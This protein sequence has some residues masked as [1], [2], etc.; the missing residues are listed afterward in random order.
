[1]TRTAAA[2]RS[3]PRVRRF[4]RR[5]SED[6]VLLSR[7]RGRY[8]HGDPFDYASADDV[9]ELINALPKD[10]GGRAGLR[11]N[12]QWDRNIRRFWDWHVVR[13]KRE[14]S[15]A[16]AVSRS[17][18]VVAMW[19]QFRGLDKRQLEEKRGPSLDNWWH[20]LE[21]AGV[22]HRAGVRDD[23]NMWWR[24][25]I[26]LLNWQQG[27]R[28]HSYTDLATGERESA[29]SASPQTVLAAPPAQLSF[30]SASGPQEAA[31]GS[32]AAPARDPLD[33]PPPSLFGQTFFRP[34]R[35]D[36]A[37]SSNQGCRPPSVT[38]DPLVRDDLGAA[39]P[40]CL[41]RSSAPGTSPAPAPANDDAPLAVATLGGWRTAAPS[42]GTAATPADRAEAHVE[43]LQA[44]V[45]A[46]GPPLPAIR[47]AFEVLSGGE[48]PV[49]TRRR[50]AQVGRLLD[51]GD[52][53]GGPG[54]EPGQQGATAWWLLAA[55]AAHYC[56][57]EPR[58]IPRARRFGGTKPPAGLAGW[59]IVLKREIRSRLVGRGARRPPQW[60]AGRPGDPRI[61]GAGA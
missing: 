31:D 10:Q 19:P 33:E 2:P 20:R 50:V 38:A 28:W 18:L 40:P 23:H 48:S 25:E 60:Q 35:D 43:Q 11:P 9:V 61:D 21:A 56:D 22:L 39:A 46:G 51:R 16:F 6:P 5:A 29:T 36:S 47:S 26:W 17:Q 49:L 53:L 14:G 52:R 12:A 32:S 58:E 55:M 13:A 8:I 57:G 7:G 1:M 4:A 42:G 24:T 3:G 37:G 54:F 44:A 34:C 45:L 59:V 27:E 30:V 15:S 41:T